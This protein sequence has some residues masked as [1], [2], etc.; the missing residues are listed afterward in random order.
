MR[1]CV[2]YSWISSD[3]IEDLRVKSLLIFISGFMILAAHVATLWSG[4]GSLFDLVLV[5]GFG[6]PLR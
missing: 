4:C 2:G 6:S 5:G 3:Q 1:G